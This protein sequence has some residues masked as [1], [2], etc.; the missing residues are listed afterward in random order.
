MLGLFD[1]CAGRNGAQMQ[2]ER[3]G[4]PQRPPSEQDY[5]K[6]SRVCAWSATLPREAASLI[7]VAVDAQSWRISTT[8]HHIVSMNAVTSSLDRGMRLGAVMDASVVTLFLHWGLVFCAGLQCGVGIVFAS[9]GQG[10]LLVKGFVPRSTAQ[11]GVIQEGDLLLQVR[12]PAWAP[13]SV[14]GG[15]PSNPPTCSQSSP[16]GPF[17]CCLFFAFEAS[18]RA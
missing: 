12:L 2:M 9:D 8:R 10:G 15:G 14:G 18:G 16:T 7:D 6:V 13:R 4:Q 17:H 5:P 1:C 3:S 11:N